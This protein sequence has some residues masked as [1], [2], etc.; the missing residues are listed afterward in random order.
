MQ[1]LNE[2]LLQLTQ[3]SS[4]FERDLS[5]N[6]ISQQLLLANNCEMEERTKKMME[7]NK[8]LSDK[9]TQLQSTVFALEEENQS[10]NDMVEGLIKDGAQSKS[11]LKVEGEKL[12]IKRVMVDKL[13]KKLQERDMII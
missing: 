13:N 2:K 12:Q 3:E 10:I 9:Q 7:E 5:Q 1:S 6:R 11:E 4:A 8:N